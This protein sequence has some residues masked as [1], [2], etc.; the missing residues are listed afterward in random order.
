VSAINDPPR[1]RLR[2]VL[3][4]VGILVGLAAA[5]LGLWLLLAGPEKQQ[6]EELRE[7]VRKEIRRRARETSVKLLDPGPL[8]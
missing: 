4:I 7:E 5:G 1:R 8:R 2:R 3:Y 6:P